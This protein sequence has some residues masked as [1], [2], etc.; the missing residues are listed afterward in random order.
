MSNI[1]KHYLLLS[2]ILVFSIGFI[3]KKESDNVYAENEDRI[4]KQPN[5]IFYLAD[6]QDVYD[7]G[8]YGNEKVNT[9]AVDRLAKEGML[10]NKRFYSSSHLR[11]KSISTFYGEISIKEW[12]FCKSYRY[13]T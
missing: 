5:L 10:F 9:A 4:E 8:C 6:D 1:F 11:T 13:K 7:Y 12:L 3:N 2:T